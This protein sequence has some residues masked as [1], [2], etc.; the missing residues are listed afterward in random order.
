MLIVYLLIFLNVINYQQLLPQ[1][2]FFTL[3]NNKIKKIIMFVKKKTAPISS[4]HPLLQALRC[5]NSQHSVFDFLEQIVSHYLIFGNSFLLKITLAD[6]FREIHI[7]NSEN[8]K[9]LYNK[10]NN[11]CGYSYV[12][13]QSNE[14]NNYLIDEY[15]GDCEVLHIKNFHPIQPPIWVVH[16]GG[17]HVRH[18]SDNQAS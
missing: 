7:L 8:V 15:S 3:F 9:L 6:S 2:T 5:P 11:H 12:I 17:S 16:C 13:W 4:N 18:R 14:C 10:H 1:Q